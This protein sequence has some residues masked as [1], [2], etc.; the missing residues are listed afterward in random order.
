MLSNNWVTRKGKTQMR[1]KV[2]RIDNN[3]KQFL[4]LRP[5]AKNHI[6]GCTFVDNDIWKVCCIN[7]KELTVIKYLAFSVKTVEDVSFW[8]Q[9]RDLRMMLQN[10]NKKKYKRI[11]FESDSSLHPAIKGETCKIIQFPGL[12]IVHGAENILFSK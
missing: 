8:W 11:F 2:R 4:E 5:R 6:A 9:C 1:E 10:K 7:V 12:M 3:E